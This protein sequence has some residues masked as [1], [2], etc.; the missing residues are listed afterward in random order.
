[1]LFLILP[2][3]TLLYCCTSGDLSAQIFIQRIKDHKGHPL[4]VV[5]IHQ[6]VGLVRVGK[7]PAFHHD[8]RCRRIPEQIDLI[9]HFLDGAV[10][11]LIQVCFGMFLDDLRQ[12]L[13]GLGIGT[14]K[15]LGSRIDGRTD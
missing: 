2:C 8:S 14:V 9:A 11:L 12:L 15:D 4:L 13:G 6:F 3:F 7:E 1:M 5:C 10:V